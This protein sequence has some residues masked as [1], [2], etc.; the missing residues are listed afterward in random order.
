[1]SARVVDVVVVGGGLAGLRAAGLL[2]GVGA[3]VVVLEARD[4]VGGRTLSQ[5]LG[6]GT[7]DLGGQWIGPRQTRIAGLARELGV[8]TFRQYAQGRKILALGGGMASYRGTIPSIPLLSA[9]D[10]HLLIGRLEWLC[11]RVPLERPYEAARAAERDGWTLEDWARRR[12]RTP[13]ARGVFEGAVRA[14]FA[15]EPDEISFLHFLSFLNAG[16]GLLQL[17]KTRG[18]AQQLRFVEGAQTISRRLAARLGDRVVLGAPVHAIEQDDDGVTVRGAFRSYRASHVVVAAPPRLAGRIAYRPALPP[19][20]TRLM[21]EV[22][23][24]SVIKAVVAYDR[25]FWREGGFSGEVVSDGE[26]VRLAF[27]ASP[28]DG[29]PGALVAFILGS[30]ARTWSGSDP[31]ARRRAVLADLTRFFGRPAGRPRGYVDQDW[32]VDEWSGG[33]YSG[34]LPPGALTGCGQALRAPIGRIHWAGTETAVRSYGY[35]DGAVESGERAAAEVAARL[36]RR[37]AQAA[38]APA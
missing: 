20:R 9:L 35:M 34:L 22:R 13:E 30:A 1:V 5:P 15:C 37:I 14:I 33:C 3:R 23:M 7:I 19:A 38:A 6:G 31:D 2:A 28:E 26:T 36:E 8:P 21:R 27:D 25:P 16:G 10:L 4:R 17:A 24:G 32:T 12:V 18:G 29:S 11:R